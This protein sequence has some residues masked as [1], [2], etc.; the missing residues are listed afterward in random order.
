MQA[1]V[2]KHG[3]KTVETG[4][5]RGTRY[6]KVETDRLKKAAKRYTGDQAFQKYARSYT[7]LLE[8]EGDDVPQ[9]CAPL[10][11]KV[12]VPDVNSNPNEWWIWC[13]GLVIEKGKRLF[14]TRSGWLALCLIGLLLLAK[15]AVTATLAKLVASSVRLAFRRCIAFWSMVL[16]S[17]MDEVIYQLEY[18]VR[19]ALPLANDIPEAVRPSN[20]LVSHFLSA[21]IGALAAV[22]GFRR[23]Q[24]QP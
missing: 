5:L 9:P 20:S 16:E 7:L 4:P 18:T 14:Q 8:L 21:G 6:D 11:I 1:L 13:K 17:L 10:A 23:N 12:K 19:E 3:H 15:P 22:M 2:A 24:V